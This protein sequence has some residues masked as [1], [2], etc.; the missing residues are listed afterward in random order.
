MSHP[1]NFLFLC[2]GN[3][4][5]SILGEAL[6]TTLSSGR[7]RGY[8]AGSHPG[9]KVNP[10]AAE[11]C[12]E[13]NYP[14]SLTITMGLSIYCLWGS[15]LVTLL[16]PAMALR[17]PQDRARINLISEISPALKVSTDAAEVWLDA[18]LEQGVLKP[19]K[20]AKIVKQIPKD[21]AKPVAKAVAKDAAKPVAKAAKVA[22]VAKVAKAPAKAVAKKK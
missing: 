2:T 13:M 17:G 16:A 1:L 12:A 8:S 10:F 7:L 6:A 14:F 19:S 20:G 21:D 22:K 5:R 3:S 18:A 9:G 11:L 15:M 4:A